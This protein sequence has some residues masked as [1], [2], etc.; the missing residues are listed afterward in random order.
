MTFL[1]PDGDSYINAGFADSFAEK[2]YFLMAQVRRDGEDEREREREREGVRD[3]NYRIV[4]KNRTPLKTAPPTF[5]R[6][7]T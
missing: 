7:K 2:N 3:P 1:P 6:R 4:P 5:S